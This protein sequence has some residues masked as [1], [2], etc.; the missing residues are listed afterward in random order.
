MLVLLVKNTNFGVVFVSKLKS[1]NY[2]CVRVVCP[3]KK[4]RRQKAT[5]LVTAATPIGDHPIT[6]YTS[7]QVSNINLMSVVGSAVCDPPSKQPMPNIYAW[8]FETPMCLQTYWMT[9]NEY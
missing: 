1:L 9:I 3:I 2:L 5:I 6:W 8:Q 7:K 4:W